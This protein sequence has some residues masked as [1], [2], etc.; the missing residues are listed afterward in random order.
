MGSS[1]HTEVERKF[2]VDPATLFPTV[3]D[4][5][6]V[7]AMSQPVDLDLEAVYFDTADLDLA[8]HGTTLRRRTGG[9]D[10]GWHLK[11]PKDADT[12]TELRLP[13]GRATRTVPKELLEPVRALVRDRRLVPVAR[14]R[15]HRREYTLLGEDE[16][17]LAQLCDDEVHAERLHGPSQTQDWREWEAELV[18]GDGPLLE[19]IEQRLLDAGATPASTT[20]KLGRTLGDEIPPYRRRPARKK[21]AGASA[22]QVVRAHLADQTAELQRQDARLRADEAGSVHKLRIAARRMRSALKTYKPLL[23]PGSGETVAEELRWLGQV[24][25][26]ARDAQVLRERLQVLVASE[27][28]ELVLGPVQARI[29]DELR[30]AYRAGLEQ[31][32]RALDSERYFRLLDALDDLVESTPLAP[33]TDAPARKLLPR[34][35]ER[36]SK[37]LRRAVKEVARA[38]DPHEHD[39]ALH[40]ARKKAKRFR[41]AAES[42]VPVLG[43]RAKSLAASVK[44]VQQALGEHQDSVVARR[45]LREYGVRAYADGQNAF[46]FGRL[47]GLEQQRADEAEREFNA[48]WKKLASKKVDRWVRK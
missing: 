4:V 15:T 19:A 42:T 14:V 7:S 44:R 21:L 17:A 36:D 27:P 30:I 3:I 43:R 46:S 35:L 25:A 23:A 6:G 20:S 47:H 38:G 39:L 32:L 22:G 45:R 12:R 37:R 24:L 11:L 13:L 1:Q 9:E 2:D 5:D 40:E 16:V 10:A 18:N 28:P 48:A 31:G 33:E 8:R 34:L 41:Y 26:D 29:D